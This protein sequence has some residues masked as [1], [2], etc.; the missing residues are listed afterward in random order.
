MRQVLIGLA[1]A[2]LGQAAELPAWWGALQRLER[3][4]TPFVQ[5]SESA[6]F[7]TVR[8]EGQLA[9]ARGGKVRVAY[10]GGLLIVADGKSLVQF[11]PAARTA[12]RL[13]LAK[14]MTDMPL[15]TLL[16]DPRRLQD[17]FR[18]TP[19][20]GGRLRLESRTPGL[21]TLEAEGQGTF[22]TSLTWTDPTG[23]RQVLRFT[24]P[25][26]PASFPEGRFTL[27]VPPGTRWL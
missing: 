13:D 24:R 8:R 9:L 16:L 7:G 22:L 14:A 26:V 15:L 18:V 3:L 1:L 4:E 6:V 27:Q 5:E 2:V 21:P 11:D 20:G 23:A 12:Q 19:L 17:A 25:R 10:Q